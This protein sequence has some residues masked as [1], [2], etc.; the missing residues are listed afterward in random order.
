MICQHYI[1]E[2]STPTSQDKTSQNQTR[3]KNVGP[4]FGGQAAGTEIVLSNIT[5]APR[6]SGTSRA[7]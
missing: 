2:G 5:P 6:R 7:G 1:L 3:Q 4:D